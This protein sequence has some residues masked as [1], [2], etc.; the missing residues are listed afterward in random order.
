M[1]IPLQ[2]L[3]SST[4]HHIDLDE[5]C[6]VPCGPRYQ[7]FNGRC[8]PCGITIALLRNAG[9]VA[10]VTDGAAYPAMKGTPRPA[11]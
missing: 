1:W 5:P 9:V 10:A 4:T 7:A 3:L 8:S 2:Y 6:Q 11:E